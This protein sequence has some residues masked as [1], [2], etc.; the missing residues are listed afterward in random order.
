MTPSR[1]GRPVAAL[2]VLLFVAAMFPTAP[3][4]TAQADERPNILIIVT[5][6][7]RRELM[8]A[9]PKTLELFRDGGRTYTN[10][11][12]TTPMCCPSRASIFTGQYVHNHGVYHNWLGWQLPETTLQSTLQEQGYRTGLFGKFLNSW[13]EGRAPS[14]FDR[15][16]VSVGGYTKARWNIDGDSR[17]DQGYNTDVIAEH[18]DSFIRGEDGSPWLAIVTPFA[19]H[20]PFVAQSEYASM[21]VPKMGANPAMKEKNRS[22]KPRWVRRQ[23]HRYRGQMDEERAKQYRTLPSVDDLVERLFATLEETDQQNTLAFFLSDNGYLWGEHGLRRKGA[24]YTDS[25][26]VPFYVRWP[27]HVAPGTTDS[28]IVANIDIASTVFKKLGLPRGRTDGRDILHDASVDGGAEEEPQRKR[29]R[30]LL[31]FWCNTGTYQCH[32]WASIRNKKW[33]YIEHYNDEKRV[34]FR[35]YYDLV[36]DPWQLRNLLGDEKTSNDPN[37]RHLRRKL[38]RDGAC[39]G[40]NCP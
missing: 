28:S 23:S 22:D 14:G 35:E 36:N 5:D 31:E 37:L 39:E 26:R 29:R 27:G 6:D 11:Y 18:A 3:H 38:R 24:P 12:V 25:V 16:A 4:A 13:G 34:A 1:A 9:M 17:T 10:A 7:Q 21:P 32:P 15:F 19:P 2:L 33:Q 30:I 40:S 8:Q 20:A